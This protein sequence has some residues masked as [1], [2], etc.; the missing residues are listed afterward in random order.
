MFPGL[1]SFCS[2]SVERPSG[3]WLSQF[4]PNSATRV[5]CP[6]RHRPPQLYITRVC[7]FVF[8]FFFFSSLAL[9]AFWLRSSVV[10][11]LF[12]LIS[13]RSL[14]RPIV[15]ILIF[16][17]REESSVLAHDSSHSVPGITLPPGDANLF[18]HCMPWLVQGYEEETAFPDV[19]SC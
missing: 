18:F 7:L 1:I 12:S 2:H 10:S 14:R 13:E 15:I 4:V 8:L 11:V 16:G 3:S 9:F 17:F 6:P 19:L 5:I